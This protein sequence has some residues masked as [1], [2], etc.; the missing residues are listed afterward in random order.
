MQ[1]LKICHLEGFCIIELTISQSGPGRDFFLRARSQS[2]SR[3]TFLRARKVAA[4]SG[5]F[6]TG[7][8]TSFSCSP[9]LVAG[10]AAVRP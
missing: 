9:P 2:S 5:V 10:A 4:G 8:A 3:A 1:S 6:V 7:H